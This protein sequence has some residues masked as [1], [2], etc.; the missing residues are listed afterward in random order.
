MNMALLYLLTM[1]AGAGIGVQAGINSQLNVAWAKN[2][3]LTAFA[4]FLVGT[5]GL[6]IYLMAARVPWPPLP[7]KIVPWH[8]TGGLLG[9][10]F[11]LIAIYAAPRL[12][13]T[14]M[15]ALILAGQIGMSLILDHFGLIGFAEKSLTWQ[16]VLGAFLVGSGVFL[17]RRF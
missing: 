3:I 7:A 5:L 9:A 4:S 15:I 10:F 2:P 8:W 11:V 1:L 13:A 12:G 6:L 16:R 14:T 17:I